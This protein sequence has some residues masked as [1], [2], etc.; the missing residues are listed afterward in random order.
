MREAS[1]RAAASY[2]GRRTEV[3]GFGLAAAIVLTTS[4]HVSPRVVGDGAEYFLVAS[5]P[6]PCAPPTPA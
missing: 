1:Y 4:L 2:V 3:V 6:I 5:A